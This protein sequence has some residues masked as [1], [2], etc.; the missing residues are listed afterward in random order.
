MKH[1]S[2]QSTPL[3][4]V[5]KYSYYFFYSTFNFNIFAST[6]L[7]TILMFWVTQQF[8]FSPHPPQKATGPLVV[9][10]CVVFVMWMAISHDAVAEFHL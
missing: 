3:M 9:F 1:E 10:R 5:Q 8:L 6:P 7:K 4:E 2:D